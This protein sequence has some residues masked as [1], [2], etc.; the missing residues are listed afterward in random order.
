MCWMV[1][2]IALWA[3]TDLDESLWCGIDRHSS[4]LH[5]PCICS[6]SRHF[7][8][9]LHVYRSI[10]CRKLCWAW[11][12]RGNFTT[13]IYISHQAEKLIRWHHKT[14]GTNRNR[15]KWRRSR[16]SSNIQPFWKILR[17]NPTGSQPQNFKW[18]WRAWVLKFVNIRQSCKIF[19]RQ[20]W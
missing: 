10:R 16:Q 19:L 9:I 15:T 18:I 12:C 11:V 8:S 7:A 17:I 4:L 6:M 5:V 20:T 2:G 13:N 3:T 14:K 1:P